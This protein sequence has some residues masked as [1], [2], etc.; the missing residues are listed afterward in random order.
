M[1]AEAQ[2]RPEGVNTKSTRTLLRVI[3]LCFIAG[4]AIASRL[5]SVIRM[6]LLARPPSA[7]RAS[8]KETQQQ[9]I[10]HVC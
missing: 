6:Y 9:C 2:T 7:L 8:E 4:A 3:I 10:T 1:T 5:F